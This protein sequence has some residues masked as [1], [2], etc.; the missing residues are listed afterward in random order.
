M[1]VYHAVRRHSKDDAV[2]RA[3][4]AVIAAVE[5]YFS[6]AV[7]SRC[8]NYRERRLSKLTVSRCVRSRAAHLS[9]VVKT[10]L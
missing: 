9:Y 6:R 5:Y 4:D 7:R 2:Q 8:Y 10:M 1:P 3:L